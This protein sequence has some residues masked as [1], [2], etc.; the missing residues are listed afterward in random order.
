[1]DTVENGLEGQEVTED[2]SQKDLSSFLK[3]VIEMRFKRRY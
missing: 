3:T 2:A 1:M